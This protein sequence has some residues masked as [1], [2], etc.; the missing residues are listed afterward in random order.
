MELYISSNQGTLRQHSLGILPSFAHPSKR[1]QSGNMGALVDRDGLI[2]PHVQFASVDEVQIC[3][4]TR[5]SIRFDISVVLEF[6][7]YKCVDS[8]VLL[9]VYSF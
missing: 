8:F 6:I 1:C 5:C 3:L 4:K 2:I 9:R 7:V